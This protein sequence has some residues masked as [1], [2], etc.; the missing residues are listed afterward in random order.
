MLEAVL[1]SLVSVFLI[2]LI[3]FVG[4]FTFGIKAV[5]LKSIIIL[6]LAFSAGALLGD[7]FFHLLPETIEN[8][9]HFAQSAYLLGGIVLFFI[10]E[11]FI[12][13]RHCHMPVSKEHK[14]PFVYTNLI[15]DGIHN[16]LDGIIIAS[17]YIVSIPVGIATTIAVAMHEIP[18]EIGDFGVLIHGGL[19]RKKALLLNFATALTAVLG[20][21]VT[22]LIA[23]ILDKVESIFVPIAIG[24]FI[25]I[26]GSDLIPELHKESDIKSSLWQLIFFIIGI[27]FMAALLYVE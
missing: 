12:H 21:I 25:Y 20:T 15:G 3:S 18:Q 6:M 24:G 5:K 4:L 2:S 17:S 10:I 8:G 1:Y 7:A 11:K 22:F 16:F 19:S 26:A 27:A 14:H 13:W 9:F 23:N